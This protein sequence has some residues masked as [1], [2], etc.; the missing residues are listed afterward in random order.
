MCQTSLQISPS[1]VSSGV[2]QVSLVFL[3]SVLAL[4]PDVSGADSSGDTVYDF[5]NFHQGGCAGAQSE[6][7]NGT[8]DLHPCATNR[9]LQLTHLLSQCDARHHTVDIEAY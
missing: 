2:L 8:H 6:T 3:A 4:L 5:H 9:H 1:S 7:W